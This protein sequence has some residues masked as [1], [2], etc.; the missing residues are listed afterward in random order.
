[1]GFSSSCSCYRYVV[2]L[3][4]ILCIFDYL[5]PARTLFVVFFCSITDLRTASPRLIRHSLCR[6][7]IPC[8]FFLHV[9]INGINV[10]GGEAAFVTPRSDRAEPERIAL[11][12]ET[13]ELKGRLLQKVNT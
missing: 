10:E 7:L 5:F 4:W 12:R 2:I 13:E 11:K 6:K 9:L 3:N 1:M 8:L